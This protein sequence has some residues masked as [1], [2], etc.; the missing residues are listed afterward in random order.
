MFPKGLTIFFFQPVQFMNIFRN[1]SQEFVGLI[2]AAGLATRIAPLPCSKEIFP[3]GFEQ[4]RPKVACHYLLDRM[5]LANVTKAFIVLRK[6]KW[7]IP[8]YFGDGKSFGLDLAY[9]IMD[10]PFGV[11]YTIDQAYPFVENSM[12]VFGFPDILFY[13][14]DAFVKLINMQN[15]SGADLVLGLFNTDRP[16]KW[17]MVD[18]DEQGKIRSLVIKPSQTTLQYTWV[19]AV[20]TPVFTRFMHQ[21]ISNLISDSE[22][23]NRLTISTTGKELYVGDVIQSAITSGLH[24]ETMVFPKGVCL[25][26]GTPGDMAKATQLVQRCS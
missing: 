10:L 25:D 19:M 17:D 14:E 23:S 3:I 16:E 2:P 12:I 4:S 9:L 15:T 6:C 8:N 7:D 18:L 5:R 24:V 13:P 26:I 11:P 21:M 20:W 22:K 1:T